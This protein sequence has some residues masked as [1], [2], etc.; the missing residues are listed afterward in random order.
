MSFMNVP[1]ERFFLGQM[2][3]INMKGSSHAI[4]NIFIVLNELNIIEVLS[5]CS[6][7]TE[8]IRDLDRS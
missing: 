6:V 5:K 1:L 3:L 8:C 4:D 7:D 2:H